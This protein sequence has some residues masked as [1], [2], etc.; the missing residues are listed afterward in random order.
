MCCTNL[1]ENKMKCYIYTSPWFAW[2]LNN[3]LMWITLPFSLRA[4][5][6]WP[7]VKILIQGT[8]ELQFINL[9]AVHIKCNFCFYLQRLKQ[10]YFPLPLTSGSLCTQCGQWAP[11]KERPCHANVNKLSALCI[12]H[13]AAL[14]RIFFLAA[15]WRFGISFDSVSSSELYLS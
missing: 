7:S 2:N 4:S 9:A 3:I 12:N 5:S 8:A 15:G 11:L 14:E 1:S 6:I 13:F 10:M